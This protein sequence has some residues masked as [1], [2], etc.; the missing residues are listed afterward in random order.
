ME[1]TVMFEM[2][3]NKNL[4]IIVNDFLVHEKLA[5]S[6]SALTGSSVGEQKTLR[7]N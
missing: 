1:D 7:E 3:T 2:Y 6:F 5:D 4:L